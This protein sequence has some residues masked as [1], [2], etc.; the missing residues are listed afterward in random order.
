[1]LDAVKVIVI[2]GLVFAVMGSIGSTSRSVTWAIPKAN[3]LTVAV[4]SGGCEHA[5]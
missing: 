5:R 1:M 2:I 4:K 3:R